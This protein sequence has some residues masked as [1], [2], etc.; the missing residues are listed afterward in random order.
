MTIVMNIHNVYNGK[1]NKDKWC[2]FFQ[3]LKNTYQRRKNEQHAYSVI[4]IKN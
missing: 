4:S 1:E 3:S 2:K